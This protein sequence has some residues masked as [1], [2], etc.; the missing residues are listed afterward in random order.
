MAEGKH[1]IVIGVLQGYEEG[2][3]CCWHHSIFLIAAK[4]ASGIWL[5]A[6]L[7]FLLSK[8]PSY[9]QH[10]QHAPIFSFCHHLVIR[11]WAAPCPQSACNRN[12]QC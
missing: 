4:R 5:V 3:L 8:C 7:L 11:W 2:V 9:L 12:S 6:S 10:H 1:G